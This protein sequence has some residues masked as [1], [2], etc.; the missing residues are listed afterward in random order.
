MSLRDLFDVD[1]P[2]SRQQDNWLRLVAAVPA[3]KRAF[4]DPVNPADEA[5]AEEAQGLLA[6]PSPAAGR[7]GGP[8]R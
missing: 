5:M 7:P 3:V 2:R 4:N 6:R 1:S 8:Q